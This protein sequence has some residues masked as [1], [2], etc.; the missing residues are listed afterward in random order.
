MQSHRQNSRV[1]R[2][3]RCTGS[4]EAQSR[5]H[6]NFIKK[7]MYIRSY[8]PGINNTTL[9]SVRISQLKYHTAYF[10]TVCQYYYTTGKLIITS[11][12]IHICVLTHLRCL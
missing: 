2:G 4:G 9:F 6:V 11:E 3:G 10:N 12:V 5:E 8:K 1:L 7:I